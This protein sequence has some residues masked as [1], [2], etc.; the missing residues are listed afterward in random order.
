MTSIFEYNQEEE[1][2]KLRAAERQV[3]YDEGLNEGR[4]IGL[5]EGQ[6]LQQYKMIQNYICKKG[7]S[8]EEACDT[9][10]VSAEEYHEAE[11]LSKMQL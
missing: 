4:S 8:L 6:R 5:N 11:K 1:E 2:R 9:L 10:D 3:G 7:V